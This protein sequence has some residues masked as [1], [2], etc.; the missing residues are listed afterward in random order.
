MGFRETLHW[1]RIKYPRF[2][3]LLTPLQ[4]PVRFTVKFVH[5]L[6]IAASTRATTLDLLRYASQR[7]VGEV[8]GLL[9]VKNEI[10][11][12]AACLAHHRRLGVREF[13][14]VDNGSTDGTLEFLM[15]QEDVNLYQTKSSYKRAHYGITWINCLFHMHAQG[16]WALFIDADELLFIDQMNTENPLKNF[17]ELLKR[18]QQTYMYAPMIDLY[19]FDDQEIRLATNV[20]LLDKALLTARQD[21]DSY[22]PHTLMKNGLYA[23]K[24]GPRGQ[25]AEFA[26]RTEPL[27]TKFPLVRYG[28]FRYFTASAHEFMP[29]AREKHVMSGWLAHLKLGNEMARRHS[30]PDIEREHYGS[31]AER[32]HISKMNDLGSVV[33]DLSSIQFRGMSSLEMLRSKVNGK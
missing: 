30:D 27:L 20:E 17:I 1:A 33:S 32:E 23:L 22:H 29:E 13:S 5:Y 12:I 8:I 9:T 7:N 2:F 18:S 4:V 11:R 31:G 6:G 28:Y 26:G 21:L 3:S 14:V 24:G 25:L 10:D 16:R 15:K 19:D